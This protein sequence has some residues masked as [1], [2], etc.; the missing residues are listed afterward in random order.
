MKRAIVWRE[1]LCGLWLV[2]LSDEY[3]HEYA[4]PT[5]AAALEHALAEV[6]LAPKEKP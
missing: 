6:G 5:H 1:S 2:S 3:L 4:F